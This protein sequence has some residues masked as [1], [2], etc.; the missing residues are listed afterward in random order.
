LCSFWNNSPNNCTFIGYAKNS[1]TY[2]FLVYKFENA[3]IHV[4]TILESKDVEF[5]EDTYPTKRNQGELSQKRLRESKSENYKDVTKEVKLRTSKRPR[6]EKSFRPYFLTY[7]LE[8]EPQTYKEAMSSPDAHF[9][10]EAVD[11]EIHWM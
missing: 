8:G 9:W 1:S 11:N 4:N 6:I 7:M 3:E 2:R 10:K 5:F